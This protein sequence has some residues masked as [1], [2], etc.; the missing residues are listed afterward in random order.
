MTSNKGSTVDSSVMR[1]KVREFTVIPKVKKMLSPSFLV[2]ADL[3]ISKI[4]MVK[5]IKFKLQTRQFLKIRRL[6]VNFF[7]NTC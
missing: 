4:D 5:K 1:L 2:L 6:Q 7:L 3:H